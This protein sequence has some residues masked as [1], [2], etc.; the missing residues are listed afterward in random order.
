M[1]GQLKDQDVNAVLRYGAETPNYLPRS[2][3]LLCGFFCLR[4]ERTCASAEINATCMPVECYAPS[5]PQSY[6]EPIC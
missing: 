5:G 3:P 1:Y 4:S 6:Q 2:L